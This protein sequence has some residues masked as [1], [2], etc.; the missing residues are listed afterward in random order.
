[1]ASRT[2]KQGYVKR[3]TDR[4]IRHN[5]FWKPLTARGGV[6]GGGEDDTVALLGPLK[7]DEQQDGAVDSLWME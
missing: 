2:D 3:N 5:T 7:L 1:M 4:A 6:G